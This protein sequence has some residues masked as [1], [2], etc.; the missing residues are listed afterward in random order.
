MTRSDFNHEEYEYK[1]GRTPTAKELERLELEDPEAFAFYELLAANSKAGYSQFRFVEGGMVF[2]PNGQNATG[3][4]LSVEHVK[5]YLKKYPQHQWRHMKTIVMD[6]LNDLAD[7][8]GF[9]MSE[10]SL[11]AF[12]DA[13][14]KAACKE[15]KKGY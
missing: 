8:N 10:T 12:T 15:L 11:V 13:T 2:S 7:E 9:K 3:F 6:L 4:D 1:M 5:L 14:F